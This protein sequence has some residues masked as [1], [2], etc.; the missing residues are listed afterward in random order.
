[1]ADY[2]DNVI[3]FLQPQPASSVIVTNG[4]DNLEGLVAPGEIVSLFGVG[5]GPVAS[6]QAQPDANGLI[7]SQLAGTTVTFNGIPAP[8]LSTQSLQDSAAVPYALTGVKSGHGGRGVSGSACRDRGRI[9]RRFGPGD[10]HI[11]FHR[12]H[13]VRATERRWHGQY[14]RQRGGGEH[15]DYGI[16]H[17]RRPD[18]ASGCGRTRC[19]GATSPAP[20]LPVTAT[21][22]GAAATVTQVATAAGLADE[23]TQ[24]SV[25]LPSS[26]TTS[27][28][29]PVVI[30]VGNV[31]SL[32]AYIAVQ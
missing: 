14:H 2:A 10:L 30:Q 6:A 9:G 17:R 8:V 25:T 15:H 23:I 27:S 11:P 7:E 32:P 3:R 20:L 5:L 13:H 4:A 22:G 18:I 26:V 29:V 24:F 19:N 1:M 31:T 16:R 28:P 21:V 12:L